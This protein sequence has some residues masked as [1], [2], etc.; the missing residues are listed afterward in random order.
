MSAILCGIEAKEVDN[1]INAVAK[2]LRNGGPKVRCSLRNAGPNVRDLFTKGGE[3][4]LNPAR[5]LDRLHD[6]E[7]DGDPR[8]CVRRDRPRAAE[9]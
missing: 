9:Q 5:L 6:E 3:D 4:G 8:A 1:A 7:A 2:H